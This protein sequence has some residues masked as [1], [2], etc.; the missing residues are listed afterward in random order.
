MTMVV[1]HALTMCMSA[2][3][4]VAALSASLGSKGDADHGMQDQYELQG[5]AAILLLG[6]REPEAPGQVT[7]GELAETVAAS[8][9]EEPE[10]P[11]EAAAES[12]AAK[13]HGQ[14]PAGPIS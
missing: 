5:K 10:N 9:S 11:A 8:Q 14:V 13:S 4:Q 2:R 6:T 3:A 7:E 12:S 1:L